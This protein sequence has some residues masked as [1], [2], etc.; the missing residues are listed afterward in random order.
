M[1]KLISHA[2]AVAL[3]TA[4]VPTLAQAQDKASTQEALV[5]S[6]QSQG[7][8]SLSDG[9]NVNTMGTGKALVA[10]NAAGHQALA[11]QIKAERAIYERAALTDGLSAGE[12]RVLDRLQDNIDALQARPSLAKDSQSSYGSCLTPNGASLYASAT[13]N[14][15]TSASSTAVNA[16]DFGPIT[17]TYNFAEAATEY[18]YTSNAAVGAT[19]ATASTS[20]P[21]SCYAYSAS[22]VTCPGEAYPG[23][24]A[25]ASSSSSAPRCNFLPQ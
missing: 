10:T 6:L 20:S 18:T 11:M 24:S 9:L 15:G 25:F 12:Q 17:P 8:T 13:S 3:S 2:V 14:N 21:R 22:S 23:V 19:A 7:F 16:L 4:L 1:N 5:D